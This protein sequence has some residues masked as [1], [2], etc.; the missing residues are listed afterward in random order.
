MLSTDFD[1]KSFNLFSDVSY[2]TL[3]NPL[4]KGLYYIYIYVEGILDVIVVV[5]FVLFIIQALRGR[6]FKFKFISKMVGDRVP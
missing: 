1:Y 6:E 2:D 3:S 4:Q 5:I